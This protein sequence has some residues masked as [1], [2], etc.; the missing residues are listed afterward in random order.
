MTKR[1]RNNG[2]YVIP[3]CRPVNSDS[4][5]RFEDYQAYSKIC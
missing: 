5:E 1:N 3:H 4:S 2:A